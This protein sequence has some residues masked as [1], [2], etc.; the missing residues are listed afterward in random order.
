M[1]N[2]KVYTTNTCPW[3]TKVKNY[4]TSKKIS[5]EEVNV[6]LN[7][8]AAIEMVSKSGQMGVP[9]LDINGSIV[10]GFDKM[11]IDSLLNL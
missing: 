3:C 1:N 4:L 6:G 11:T 8:D 10:V 9:V 7:R 5:Y 2:I